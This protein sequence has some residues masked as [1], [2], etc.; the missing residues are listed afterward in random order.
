MICSLCPRKCNAKR[1]AE[2]SF[3]GFCRSPENPKIARYGLHFWEEPPISGKNGSGTIF[4]S[5]CSLSCVYCQNYEIS[6]GKKGETVS[7]GRLAEIFA[8]LEEKGAHNINLVTADHYCT[9]VRKALEI[10]RPKIPVLLNTSGYITTKQLE[11]LGDF[12]D[13]YLVD[14]KYISP[15]RAKKYSS[16][17]DY[18]QVA[19]KAIDHMIAKQ[20]ECVFDKDGILQK[21][22]II[23]HLLMPLATNEAISVFDRVLEKYPK[24]YFS[25]MAQYIP[26]GELESCPEINRKITKRE[27]EKVISHV[28][29][30]G[31]EN[32]FVQDLSSA[33]RKFIPKF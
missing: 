3:S 15:D 9:A 24:A 33:D 28:A 2:D 18:P 19:Q 32:C 10:Y 26:V 11:L 14:F 16:A 21:G 25:L 23:R 13:I 6:R 12:I 1:T 7:V 30:S 4:F 31:F 20:P 27:Y 17:E 5:G 8:E 22:V 29:A